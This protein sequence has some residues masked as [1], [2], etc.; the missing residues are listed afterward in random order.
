[1]MELIKQRLINF[2]LLIM[3]LIFCSC[4][5]SNNEIKILETFLDAYTSVNSSLS[6]KTDCIAISQVNQMQDGLANI[7]IIE[8]DQ[9][10]INNERDLYRS[11]F[12]GVTV[13]LQYGE[14]KSNHVIKPLVLDSN[15]ISNQMNWKLVKAGTI[16]NPTFAPT[17]YDEYYETNFLYDPCNKCI[18]RASIVCI[19]KLRDL[20]VSKC[21]AWMCD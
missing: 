17:V 10:K 12:N 15:I 18:N 19:P 2:S 14:Q 11:S 21:S 13:Y 16:N 5:R 9:I 3:I 4:K 20:L 7:A 8:L 6:I 1:M